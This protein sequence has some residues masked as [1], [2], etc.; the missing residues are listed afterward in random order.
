MGDNEPDGG[1]VVDIDPIGHPVVFGPIVGRGRQLEAPQVCVEC[2]DILFHT[3]I[4]DFTGGGHM[5]LE[6]GIP[7]QMRRRGGT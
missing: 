2:G 3:G 7:R 6:Q 5:A 1:G 4:I